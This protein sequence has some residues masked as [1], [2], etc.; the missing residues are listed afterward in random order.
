MQAADELS[1]HCGQ[2][3]IRAEVLVAVR[4]GRELI[5]GGVVQ[6]RFFL[7]TSK[8]ATYVNRLG[9]ATLRVLTRRLLWASVLVSPYRCGCSATLGP[10]CGPIVAEHTNRNRRDP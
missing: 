7:T 5:D 4:N 8:G 9:S 6:M 2:A 1:H 10:L 3:A